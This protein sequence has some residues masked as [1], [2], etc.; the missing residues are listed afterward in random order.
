MCVALT[1]NRYQGPRLL[2]TLDS[3]QDSKVSQL[4]LP[5][6][7]RGSID[8]SNYP[9]QVSFPSIILPCSLRC[10]LDVVL[11]SFVSQ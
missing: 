5:C 7:S 9:F 11:F 2:N 8:F 6:D 10:Y 1:Q 4:S 3:S